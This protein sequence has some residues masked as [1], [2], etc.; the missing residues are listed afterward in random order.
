MK[1]KEAMAL[2]G[3]AGL[4]GASFIF[5]RIAS[6]VF[7]PLLTIQG[8]VTIAAIA[9]FIYLAATGQFATFQQR[10]KQY[11]IIGALNAA[12]PF[13]CIA[14]AELYLPASMSSILNS[15]TPL[16]TALVVWSWMKERLSVR[17][18]FGLFV[19]VVGVGI[20]VGWSVLPLN[21][22]TVMAI[23][24]SVLSTLSYSFAGVY[25][26]KAFAGVSPLSLA[27]GQQAGASILL[28]PF[29]LA[30]LPASATDFSMLAVLSV[31]GLALFCTS[32]AYLLY[33]YLIESV[34]P[35]KTL[36]VTFLIPIFGILWSVIF[37][38][39][40]LAIGTFIGLIIILG[41]VYLISDIRME[42]WLPFR[43][44]MKS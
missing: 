4:W 11:L 36:S 13:T 3:L 1:F 18:W 16:F 8:R 28:I 40:R 15:L 12:L 43:N 31:V 9:L 25:A 35:T 20:L 32:F 7:G 22:E 5:I 24:F 26:K 37:L 27:T 42:V 38:G 17:K 6:P 2:I 39:E 44:K 41:G 29:T 19:G 10:W 21:R 23:I 34:G 33:F 30:N 14:I